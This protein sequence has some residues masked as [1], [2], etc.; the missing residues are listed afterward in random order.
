MLTS[1]V[2]HDIPLSLGLV[3]CEFLGKER[4]FADLSVTSWSRRGLRFSLF[5]RLL[6]RLADN[7]DVMA[8]RDLCH[9]G[10]EKV[11]LLV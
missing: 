11:V 5:L 10:G 9:L 1:R 8:D 4:L 3:F 6:I 7:G 2:S